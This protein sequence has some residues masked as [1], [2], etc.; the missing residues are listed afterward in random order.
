MNSVRIVETAER[1]VCS[2]P[3]KE[4]LSGREEEVGFEAR[5]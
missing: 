4:V 1:K 5:S 3:R 2:P